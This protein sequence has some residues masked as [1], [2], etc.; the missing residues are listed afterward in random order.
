M[1]YRNFYLHVQKLFQ[2]LKQEVIFKQII[3]YNND[4][5]V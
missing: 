5:Y 3:D 1:F 2:V 4:D